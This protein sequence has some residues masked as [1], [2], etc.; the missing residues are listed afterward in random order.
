MVLDFHLPDMT[1]LDVLDALREQHGEMMWPVVV[2]T[3]SMGGS[4][5]ASV[6]RSGAEDFVSKDSNI[7][8]EHGARDRKCEGAALAHA[9]VAASRGA[10]ASCALGGKH[11]DM[12]VEPRN[13]PGD[14][15]G[16]SLSHPRL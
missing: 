7:T 3:S 14:L 16:R 2:L 4:E 15:V 12:G 9:R 1:G 6:L 5:P 11:R 10:A 8:G 13:R